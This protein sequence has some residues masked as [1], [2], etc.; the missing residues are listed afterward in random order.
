MAVSR[1]NHNEG[2]NYVS[3]REV[4]VDYMLTMDE[5]DYASSATEYAIRNIALRGIREFGFD[6]QPSVRSLKRPLQSNNTIILPDDFV[7]VIKIGTVD[8]NGI[9]RAFAENKNLNI[10]Q[11]YDD[12]LNITNQS[13]SGGLDDS[14][15]TG[16]RRYIPDNQI[17]NRKDDL[18]ATNSEAN[19]EDIDWYIFENYL[20]QGSL[21]RMYG[22]GGGKLRGTYRINYDQNRIE[23]DSEAGVTEVVIEYIS[24][25]ARS[26][27]PVIH[28]Y[29]EEA[30]RAFIYYKIVERKS[31]VPAG[32]K[33][34]ARQEY[35]N[36]R[37]K[38]RGRLS[39]FSKTEALNVIRR[40]FKLVPKY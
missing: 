25:A 11:A 27:D 26:T 16:N 17:E 37:R 33:A 34:R 1:D 15:Q 14:D 24:D 29:A 2:H 22:L 23:I 3:L 18:T 4:I 40:N 7:D 38:A 19:N 30:L 32:E 36:E 6:V 28:V 8:E 12:N 35:Y 20:Y 13:S 39:N 10:S 31:S 21:G 9:V 5:D